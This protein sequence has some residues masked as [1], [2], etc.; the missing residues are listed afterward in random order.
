[1]VSI[2]LETLSIALAGSVAVFGMFHVLRDG[3]GADEDQSHSSGPAMKKRGKIAQSAVAVKLPEPEF[4]FSGRHLLASY[5]GCD[6]GAIRDV[7]GLSAAML[8]AVKASGATL[9]SASDH[10]FPPDGMTAVLLLSESHASIHTYPEH[11]SCFVDIF[12]CGTTCKVEAFD[13]VLRSFLRPRKHS[14]RIIARHDEMT[15]ESTTAEAAA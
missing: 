15:D 3:D 12:T 14:R 9:L 10:I 5:S 1:M 7:K 6:P 11:N 4:E 2:W 8:A 13:A